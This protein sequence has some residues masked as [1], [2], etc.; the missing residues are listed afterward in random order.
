[1]NHVAGT[2]GGQQRLWV[3]AVGGVLHRIEVIEVAKEFIE[4]VHGRQEL[5]E[6]AEVVLAKM[7]RG[8]PMD[9]SAV[10]IV[11]ACAGMP[12]GEPAWPTVVSPVRIGS[13]PVMK[14]A[15]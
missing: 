4:A 9:F 15:R 1:M 5:V 8:V 13:S 6:V 10:A 7:T 3:V 12:I 11:G 2:D 14:L